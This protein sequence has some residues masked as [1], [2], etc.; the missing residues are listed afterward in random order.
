L[1][2]TATRACTEFVSTGILPP[3]QELLR[4]L[5]TGDIREID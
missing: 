2:Y 3:S 5:R 1:A 4:L